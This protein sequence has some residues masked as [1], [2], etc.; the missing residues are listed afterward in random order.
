MVKAPGNASRGDRTA[1]AYRVLVLGEN[2]AATQLLRQLLL[3]QGLNASLRD[4]E[5]GALHAIERAKPDL[6]LYDVVGPSTSELMALQRIRNCCEPRTM[7]VIV[8]LPT[9]VRAAIASC[10]E[11][12]ASDFLTWPVDWMNWWPRLRG[13]LFAPD[14]D[15]ESDDRRSRSRLAARLPNWPFETLEPPRDAYRRAAVAAYGRRLN[16]RV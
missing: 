1:S 5:E 9:R 12:G 8:V 11:A 2:A 4:G 14:L 13:H 10:I 3:Q 6:V 16:L 15:A 7:P